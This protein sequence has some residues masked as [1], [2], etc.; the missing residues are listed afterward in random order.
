[1]NLKAFCQKNKLTLF[2]AAVSAATAFA[3]LAVCSKSSFLYAFNDWVDAN[4][5]FTVGKSMAN[6]LTLYKDIFEQKGILLYVIHMLSYFISNDSFFFFFIFEVLAAGIFSFIAYRFLLLYNCKKSSFITVPLFT[7]FVYSSHAFCQGDS[8]EEFCLPFLLGVMYLTFKA[9]KKDKPLN[10]KQLVTIGI[11][12]ACVLWIKYTILGFYIGAAIIAFIIIIKNNGMV[13]VLKSVVYVFLGILIITVPVFI[14]FLMNNAVG[15]MVEV[16]FYDNM[17]LYSSGGNASIISKL[18]GLLTNTVNGVLKT[19]KSNLFIPALS[20]AGLVCGL[21]VDR[22]IAVLNYIF[23]YSFAALFIFG[24]GR[25]YDYYGLPFAALS[26]YGAV[27]CTV[28]LERLSPDK[29]KIMW[30]VTVPC[31]I[32]LSILIPYFLSDNVGFALINREQLPQYKFKKIIDETSG[33]GASATLLNYGSLDNGFYT[34]CDIMPNC[35]YFCNLNI[36]LDTIMI[37]Q[38]KYVADKRVDYIVTR[39]KKPLNFSGYEC[40][41]STSYQYKGGTRTYFLYHI[42]R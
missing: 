37:E 16:Y 19:Y 9:I 42:S 29:R 3:V 21:V 39:G 6:G 32:V 36:P 33:S 38:D 28:G 2:Q 27:F 30:R 4:C 12:A 14:Y 35:K 13:K 18:A 22:K 34:V 40:I 26:F 7:A 20:C 5:F 31:V 41:S 24:G 15:D 8:A 23:I 1:M 10:A 11:C 17:F 25:S